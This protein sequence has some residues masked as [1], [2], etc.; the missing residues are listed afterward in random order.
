MHFALFSVF[1]LLCIIDDLLI[2]L[3]LDLVAIDGH[4]YLV[5]ISLTVDHYLVG[6]DHL[7]IMTYRH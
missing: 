3:D 6:I 5:D 2:D 4:D 7:L 1:V